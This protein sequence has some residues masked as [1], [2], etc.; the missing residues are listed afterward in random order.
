M[1]LFITISIGLTFSKSN[2]PPRFAIISYIVLILILLLNLAIT[3][4]YMMHIMIKQR[5][6]QPEV[7]GYFVDVNGK[8]MNSHQRSKDQSRRCCDIPPSFTKVMY[9]KPMQVLL[10]HVF[11]QI[12]PILSICFEVL[13]RGRMPSRM[14][15]NIRYILGSLGVCVEALV[16]LFLHD[17]TLRHV[18]TR[19]RVHPSHRTP[20]APSQV[21]AP[22]VPH[23]H[24]WTLAT[25]RN[26]SENTDTVNCNRFSF[27]FSSI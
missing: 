17:M 21:N 22:V 16:Y 4:I 6:E 11:L 7:V 19:S 12:V 13:V 8:P 26:Q 9:S 1:I 3:Y 14:H 20:P 15:M 24:V 18:L 5:L 10:L 25:L 27:Q 23:N 2:F